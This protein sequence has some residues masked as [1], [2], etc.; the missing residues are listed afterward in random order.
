MTMRYRRLIFLSAMISMSAC[1]QHPQSEQNSNADTDAYLTE[2]YSVWPTKSQIS[3][4]RLS[5]EL[6]KDISYAD[7][8]C[9]LDENRPRKYLTHF[10]LISTHHYDRE[11]LIA[12][13]KLDEGKPIFFGNTDTILAEELGDFVRQHGKTNIK[14]A[15]PKKAGIEQIKITFSKAGKFTGYC[16][17]TFG[18]TNVVMADPQTGEMSNYSVS[19]N[20]QLVSIVCMS[21]Q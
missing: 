17:D 1:D 5:Q 10:A 8:L 3:A 14:D 16:A 13:Y 9:A 12:T 20:T 2:N 15:A 21:M 19:C 6:Q 4:Q 7:K 18:Y 11:S